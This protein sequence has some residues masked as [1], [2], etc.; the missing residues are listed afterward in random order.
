MTR[1][2]CFFQW[3]N[4]WL[5]EHRPPKMGAGKPE[6]TATTVQVDFADAKGT[7]I[8]EVLTAFTLATTRMTFLATALPHMKS[9]PKL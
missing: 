4:G 5:E 6:I 8:E 3:N 2:C 7:T 1:L 9:I